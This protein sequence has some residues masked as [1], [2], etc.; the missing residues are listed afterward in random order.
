MRPLIEN[1]VAMPAALLILAA[2]PGAG[3]VKAQ[4]AKLLLDLR[5]DWK[6]EL[7]DDSARVAPGFDDSQWSDI[8][9]PSAWED[10][11]FPGYDGYAWYRKHFRV[12]SYWMT[13]ELS[14]VIGAIDDVDEVFINGHIIGFSGSFPPHYSTAYNWNRVY[15]VPPD[16]F[17]PNED[18]VIAIRVY[19]DQLAGGIVHGPVGLYDRVDILHPDVSIP[20]SWQFKTGDNMKWKEIAFDDHAWTSV[21]VP[22]YWET[23]GFKDYDG[24]AWYRV[25]FQIP[26]GYPDKNIVL[27]LGKI[28]DVDETYLNGE[29]IGRTG[30]MPPEML[31]ENGSQESSMQRAYALPPGLL[32]AGAENVLAVR[33][34]DGYLLGGIYEGPI[35]I[36]TRD[37]YIQYSKHRNPLHWLKTFFDELFH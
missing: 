1:F 26:T 36:I 32:R 16:F 22:A 29:R 27:L 24:F 34:Y 3:I 13:K 23:Q 12:S 17:T 9:V 11:G 4:D 37:H 31:Y 18:N 20:S 6:F 30:Y 8:S 7:G 25:K 19:D 21:H 10:Q 14:V 15:P 35:G 5:G 2:L 28:D 33:V